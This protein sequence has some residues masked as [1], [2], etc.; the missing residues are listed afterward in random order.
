M[1]DI[2]VYNRQMFA[3]LNYFSEKDVVGRWSFKL[4]Q[5]KSYKGTALSLLFYTIKHNPVYY[6]T[7]IFILFSNYGA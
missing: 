6:V 4:L 7:E 3:T 1:C 2:R 5:L